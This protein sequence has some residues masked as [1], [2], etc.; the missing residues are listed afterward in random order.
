MGHVLLAPDKFKG[1][2]TAVEVVRHLT[3]GLRRAAPDIEVRGF[4]VADGGDGT[5]DAAVSAG[6]RRVPV[7]VAGPTGAEVRTAFGYADGV[8][9]V[10]LADACGLRR[11]PAGVPEPLRASSRGAGEVIR[12]ALAYG[13]SE[14]VLGLGGSASTDGGAGLVGALG[15]RLLDES[16]AELSPGGAALRHLHR[17]DL[18][19]LHPA[20]RRTRFVVA[21]D[22]D[23]PLLGP[24]GA[25]AVY[26]PQKGATADDVA[27][28]EAG[29]T[30]WADLA[31]PAIEAA[32]LRGAAPGPRVRDRAGAGAAGGV[33][34]A[35]LG[36]L[37]ARFR[38][39]IELLL[40]LLGFAEAVAGADLVVT[41]EGSLDGQSLHGK[42]P[43]GVAGAAV[44]AGVP[45]VAVAGQVSVGPER[46]RGAGIEAVYPLTSVEP[47]P[48]ACLDRAAELVEKVAEL[49]AAD[50][51]DRSGRV[52][53]R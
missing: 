33:G 14:V 42:A 7:S 2:L 25:A 51:L 4:P 19:G 8:A 32:G 9:V 10:E 45:T 34:F 35:A 31:E 18:T 20:V 44:L 41:G 22:V 11:L 46:L 12:A 40:D 3:A 38:P 17:V 24:T 30:R 52:R 48:A 49:L 27:V 29:L 36:F 50:W 21:G 28:L 13:C 1:S 39:G 15:V 23:N 16:G 47:D 37:G 53:R 26:G 43:V 6:F 5:L